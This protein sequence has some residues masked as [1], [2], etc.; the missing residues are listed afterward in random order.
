MARGSSEPLSGLYSQPKPLPKEGLFSKVISVEFRKSS[1]GKRFLY[2]VKRGSVTHVPSIRSP[3]V[4]ALNGCAIIPSFKQQACSACW[5][6]YTGTKGSAKEAWGLALKDIRTPCKDTPIAYVTSDQSLRHSNPQLPWWE[7]RKVTI[8]SVRI[9]VR[10]EWG[11]AGCYYG[12]GPHTH[13]LLP[14]YRNPSFVQESTG[15][16]PRLLKLIWCGH[17]DPIP[18][19]QILT[20]PAPLVPENVCLTLFCA[21]KD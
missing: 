15:P 9:L 11:A 12:R 19:C 20:F 14:G 2:P 21:M 3:H 13:T 10:I 6:S 5:P 4:T 1:W 8:S 16:A 17:D 18:L 7:M